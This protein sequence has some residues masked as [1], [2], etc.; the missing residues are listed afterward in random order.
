MLRRLYDWTMSLAARKSAEVW[1]AVIAFVES[2]VFLVPADVL[3][4]PMALAK[5]ER[6][7]RYALIATVASVL[8]GIAGWALGYYAYDAI[9][10]P[11]LE[12]YGKLDAFEQLRI[13]IHDEWEILLLLLVTSGLAH[14]PPIKVVTILAGVIHMN[15]GFFVLSAIVA[16]GAR[17]FFLA[18][19][20]RRYGEPIRH[21]IEKRLG[22][23]AGVIAAVA[24]ALGIAY[25]LLAH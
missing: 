25:K 13:Y 12:F 20:L 15:L 23:V 5:P 18:W 17:F 7:Y 21:F 3:Y 8:G 22:Q 11:V 14:L 9:A 1:L 19:L 4:L 2:S 6:A 16:R 24:I 10:R